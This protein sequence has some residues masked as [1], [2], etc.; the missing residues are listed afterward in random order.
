MRSAF[1][2]ENGFY[3]F[4]RLEFFSSSLICVRALSIFIAQSPPF[5]IQRWEDDDWSAHGETA[6][7]T[8]TGVA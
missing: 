1:H 5:T 4:P 7:Q 2:H 3:Y 6:F 8:T